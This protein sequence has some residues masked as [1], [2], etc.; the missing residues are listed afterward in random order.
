[1]NVVESCENSIDIDVADFDSAVLSWKDLA[2]EPQESSRLGCQI[3]LTKEMIDCPTQLEIRI[4]EG[5]NNV[6]S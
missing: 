2:Y 1:M 3:R 6:W 5:V 4:P